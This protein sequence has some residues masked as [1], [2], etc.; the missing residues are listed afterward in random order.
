M[1]PNFVIEPTHVIQRQLWEISATGPASYDAVNGDVIN[2]QGTQFPSC[3][4]GGFL[5][6]SGNY[7]LNPF[8]SITANLRPQWAFQ[9]S[10]SGRQGVTGVVQNVAG[11]GMTP[12]TYVITATGGGGIGAQISVV[13][14]TATTLGTI[15][16]LKS[17]AGYTSAP[18]F[19]LV[20]GG[21]SATLT[22]SVAPGSGI[23]PN[24]TNLSTEN[25]QFF[26]MGGEI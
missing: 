6:Q 23:V 14:A 18:T 2:F 12:G 3:I 19:T 5:T 21:T 10:Y 26:V 25:V 15:T 1:N 16:V 24:G 9:W 13:V 17:G 4:P 8:P 11:T 22:A 20:A 7:Q